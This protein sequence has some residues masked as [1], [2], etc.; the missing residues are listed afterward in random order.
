M[1]NSHSGRKRALLALLLL[2]PVPSLGVIAAMVVAPGPV[3]QTFSDLLEKAQRVAIGQTS[4]DLFQEPAQGEK[5][6]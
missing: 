3:G 4:S 2:A 5:V 1:V 6:S